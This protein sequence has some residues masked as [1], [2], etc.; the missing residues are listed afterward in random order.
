MSTPE[1]DEG[2]SSSAA[3]GAKNVKISTKP[4]EH[5]A[6]SEPGQKTISVNLNQ[7]G[8]E[9]MKQFCV[10]LES[11]RHTV[12]ILRLADGR[13]SEMCCSALISA[14]KAK[15]SS[16]REL[17]LNGVQIAD[18]LQVKLLRDALQSQ[19]CRIST[20]RLVNCGLTSMSCLYL[21]DAIM[22][23]P[24]H[25]KELDLSLNPLEDSGIWHLCE[26]LTRKF[27][28]L[29]RLKLT[30]CHLSEEACEYLCSLLMF[31]HSHLQRLDLSHNKLKDDGI[32]KLSLGLRS[33]N[34]RLSHLS[35]THCEISDE[36]CAALVQA[37][38]ERSFPMVELDL[39]GNFL[40]VEGIKSLDELKTL[41]GTG[42]TQQDLQTAAPTSGASSSS[43]VPSSDEESDLGAGSSKGTSQDEKSDANEFQDPSY[44]KSDV[45]FHRRGEPT[46]RFRGQGPGVFLC[47]LTGL[48]FTMTQE[49]DL[50]YEIIQWNDEQLRSTGKLPAGPLFKIWG[51]T[52]AVSQLHFQHCEESPDA[53]SCLSVVHISDDGI[54]F[55]EPV[56]SN[57]THVVVDVSR[58]SSFGLVIDFFK[59]MLYIERPIRSQILLFHRPT[60]TEDRQKVNV[61]LLPISIPVEEVSLDCQCMR[62]KRFLQH[63]YESIAALYHPF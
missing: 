62:T 42:K 25:L 33:P 32:K 34:C 26:G 28:R 41:I 22:W 1:L 53:L 61:F 4:D 40:S 45:F 54:T 37:L 15:P 11:S 23:N 2:G 43:L 48:G 10:D 51:Q 13:L 20:L 46:Y 18:E 38:K 59:K 50:M 8:S 58:F 16:L 35:L 30:S 31:D 57:K 3:S 24:S 5:V 9:E 56:T 12:E 47:K 49:G 63:N 21:Y 60:W 39:E 17:H 52:N 55:L 29:E 36:G 19:H 44:F 7:M 27:C 14:L 6:D